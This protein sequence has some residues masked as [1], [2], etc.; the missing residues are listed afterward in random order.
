MALNKK[1]TNTQK[2]Q[3]RFLRNV[4]L[5]GLLLFVLLNFGLGLIPRGGTAGWFSLY[6]HLIPGRVR[7]PFGEN[8]EDAYN[9]SLYD[10]EAMF[11]SHEINAGP[12][13]QNEYRILL[14]GDSA[15]WG[16]L[17]KPEDTLSGLINTEGLTACDG[18]QVRAYNLAYP[19]L[20]LVKD[21][22]ILD[23]ALRFEP[24]LILWPVTLE[25][26][27]KKVQIDTPLVANNPQRV[28]PLLREFDLELETYSEAFEETTYWERTLIGRRRAILDAIQLQ[29]YG[30]MWAATGIDQTYPTDYTPALRDF[31][32][33]ND[34]FQGWGPPNLP[35]H[36][37]ATEVLKAGAALAGDVPVLVI[38]EPILISQGENSDLR[39]NHFYPRWAYDQYRLMMAERSVYADWKYVDL[40]DFV[41]PE[42][43]TN[44]AVHLTPQGMTV[45]FQALL[46]TIQNAVCP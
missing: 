23:A 17:L 6:N 44:S 12:K 5:K 29:L 33:G 1:E 4:I 36:L 37:L 19:T 11:A 38:N 27:P 13:P 22:M 2:I 24:D 3:N 46:P 39:Y 20:S 16:T 35:L 45:Y 15:T 26:F 30:V 25:S 7:L 32:A 9:L 14:I 31:E 34:T 18:R 21:L 40:W 43:F 28:R 10:L 8:P 41:P 42:E